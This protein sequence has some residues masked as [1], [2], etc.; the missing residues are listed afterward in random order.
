MKTT[1]RKPLVRET[2][3]GR[4]YEYYPLGRY[5]VSAPWICRGRPTFKYTRIEVANI[6]EMLENGRSVAELV[7]GYEGRISAEAIKEAAK[8]AARVLTRQIPRRSNTVQHLN[9]SWPNRR[10][11]MKS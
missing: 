1:T 7:A 9:S 8:Q 3:G 6:L 10:S 4:P 5:V 2:L 11:T